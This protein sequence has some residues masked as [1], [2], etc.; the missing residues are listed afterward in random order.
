MK[1]LGQPAVSILM[2]VK[3]TGAYLGDCVQSIVNQE[4][5]D[6][7]LIAVNDQSR[8]NSTEILNNCSNKD[9]RIK[10]LDNRGDGIIDALRTAYTASKGDFITRMDSDDLMTKDK[11]LLMYEQLRN[12]GKGNV[13]VGLVEYFSDTNL[14][15]GY[16]QYAQWLN[17]L[18]L[19]EANFSDIYKEC[20][21]PSPCWMI[22][23]DDLI[24]AG[25][26]DSNVYP[27]DYDLAF[28]FR[29]HGLKIAGVMKVIHHWRDYGSRTSRIHEHYSDNLFSKLKVFHF[30]DQDRDKS[31]K[32][33]LWG[34]GAKGKQVAQLL[35]N[36]NVKFR[37]ICNNEKKIGREI[38]DVVL[39]DMTLLSDSNSTQVI[40]AVSS[41]HDDDVT[42]SLIEKHNRHE[43]FRFC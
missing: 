38:Y 23:R 10:T 40:V 34:A 2:P 8:D 16:K 6:W 17:H 18:T 21:V 39:E 1:S 25:G 12:S 37:W 9:K 35:N 29:K 11:L 20:T 22:Y 4:F 31:K 33:I 13:A 27:E 19:A 14:G 30:L 43:Y 5:Q 3:N 24:R 36:E 41:G 7:E 26:F 28:R 32:L 42:S 15:E